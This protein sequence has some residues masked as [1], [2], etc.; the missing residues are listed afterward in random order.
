MNPIEYKVTRIGK[1]PLECSDSDEYLLVNCSEDDITPEQ[2]QEYILGIV[3]RDT[4]TAGAYF[5]H[6]VTCMQYPHRLNEVIAI[7]HHQHNT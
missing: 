3:Y 2:V 5:C 4:H 7:V 6:H 1:L